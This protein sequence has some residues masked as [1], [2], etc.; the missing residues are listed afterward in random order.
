MFNVSF[1]WPSVSVKR[2][3]I[4]RFKERSEDRVEIK[5]EMGLRVQEVMYRKLIYLHFLDH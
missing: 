3:S 5:Q 4:V 1:V 2:G